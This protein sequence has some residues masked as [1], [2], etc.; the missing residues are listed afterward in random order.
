MKTILFVL[1]LKSNEKKTKNFAVLQIHKT[2]TVKRKIFNEWKISRHETTSHLR[3]HLR[4]ITNKG[5]YHDFSGR[6]TFEN[7][8]SHPS[9]RS[10]LTYRRQRLPD[11]PSSFSNDPLSPSTWRTMS[12]EIGNRTIHTR[13]AHPFLDPKWS[14]TPGSKS[15]P[16]AVEEAWQ[17]WNPVCELISL[18]ISPAIT[19]PPIPFSSYLR[20]RRDIFSYFRPPIVSSLARTQGKSDA[21]ETLFLRDNVGEKRWIN[22]GCN[23]YRWKEQLFRCI[24][25]SMK[26]ST[27][28]FHKK[29]I[30]F[31][32]I[33]P[34]L[35]LWTLLFLFFLLLNWTSHVRKRS[36]NNLVGERYGI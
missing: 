32:L 34:L 17:L 10:V 2:K 4:F 23:L 35:F 7:P 12:P 36:R 15:A 1:K 6:A 20:H 5:F 19:I 25:I 29:C 33:L 16:D 8:L 3:K 24:T 13:R 22:D 21:N 9:E 18:L 28:S 14:R 27:A 31:L 26:Y 11:Y 30:L